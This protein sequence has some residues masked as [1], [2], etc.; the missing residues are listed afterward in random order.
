MDNP[1][2]FLRELPFVGDQLGSLLAL[3]DP[4]QERFEEQMRQA[5]AEYEQMR[6]PAAAAQMQ[7]LQQGLSLF[8]P[9]NTSLEA[10]Y[11]P[12]AKFSFGDV[13]QD[14]TAGMREPPPN[15]PKKG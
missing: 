12:Q 10:M 11:G 3:K 8:D 7:G 4:A 13:F 15:V 6:G 1:F 9:L 2:G 14:P 5:A